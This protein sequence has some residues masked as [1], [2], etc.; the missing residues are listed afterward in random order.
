MIRNIFVILTLFLLFCRT[1]YSEVRLV[2][3]QYNTIQDAVDTAG[4]GDIIR[5][6]DGIYSE[7]GFVNISVIDEY[8]TI[9]SENGPE[10]CIIDLQDRNWGFKFLNEEGTPKSGYTFRCSLRGITVRNCR[11]LGHEQAAV[12][13]DIAVTLEDCIFEDNLGSENYGIA[14]FDETNSVEIINCRFSG[15]KSLFIIHADAGRLEVTNCIFQNNQGRVLEIL[16]G[17]NTLNTSISNCIFENN[18]SDEDGAAI[19]YS[20]PGHVTITSSSFINNRSN[21]RGGALFLDE[22]THITLGAKPSDGN[23]FEG[24]TAI[25]GA[26]IFFNCSQPPRIYAGYNTFHGYSNSDY[27]VSSSFPIHF[28]ENTSETEPILTDVYVSCNGNDANSGTSPDK[29]FKTIRRALSL[30]YA[31]FWNPVTIHLAGG[32]YNSSTNGDIFPL[33]LIPYVTI[34]GENPEQTIIEPSSD[35]PAFYGCW[36]EN[37]Q[38]RNLTIR[39]AT[40]NGAIQ[41]YY[42][43]SEITNCTFESNKSDFGGAIYSKQNVKLKISDC[44]F[45]MNNATESGGGIYI[46]LGDHVWLSNCKFDTNSAHNG[47]GGAI[48]LN[49]CNLNIFN[50]IFNGNTS[51][52]GG[53]AL[54]LDKGNGRISHS[55]FTENSAATIGGSIYQSD[56]FFYP[57]NCLFK[58]NQSERGAG[59]ASENNAQIEMAN[60]NLIENQAGNYGEAINLALGT[61]GYIE[62][63]IIRNNIPTGLNISPGSFAIVRYSNIEDGYAGTGNFDDDPL[64]VSGPE[65]DYYLSQTAAGQEYDS[66]CLDAGRLDAA[67]TCYRTDYWTLCMDKTTTRTDEVT[68]EEG[69]DTGLHYLQPDY[70]TPTPPPPVTPTAYISPTP[71]PLPTEMIIDIKLSREYLRPGDL[72]E[73]RAEINAHGTI[74]YDIPVFMILEYRLNY[75]FAPSWTDSL[76]YVLDDFNHYGGVKTFFSFYWPENAGNGEA[77][78]WS[79]VMDR[80]LTEVLSNIDSQELAWTDAS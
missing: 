38:I 76:D 1:I 24:N 19:Y 68:D 2:P 48:A 23:Y 56:G 46:E 60:C 12:N 72:F 5:V 22:H 66:S 35:Q 78:F 32:I 41:L 26:D 64:F 45:K 3:S 25:S 34:E 57:V 52:T 79:A 13:S 69:V 49:Q 7:P 21:G 29:P 6:A 16:G 18:S 40:T 11:P 42:H 74:I 50:C 61:D 51:G 15:N 20:N 63:T 4:N 54:S 47:N 77:V 75:F 65:G 80:E 58:A 30:V 70:I 33:P 43:N 8:I 37:A 59:I 71:T 36:D 44:D 14:T 17:S 39:N 67:D 27:Y 53:G 73:L 55:I 31:D 9:E 28:G 10:N 62:N